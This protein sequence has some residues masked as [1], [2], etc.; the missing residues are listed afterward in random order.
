MSDLVVHEVLQ[1]FR[2]HEDHWS[3]LIYLMHDLEEHHDA[4]V[5]LGHVGGGQQR[6]ISIRSFEVFRESV[7][8]EITHMRTKHEQSLECLQSLYEHNAQCLL[9]ITALKEENQRLKRN[10]RDLAKVRGL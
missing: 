4:E 10:Q 8:E 3:R 7:L 5:D 2:S 6:H 9:S 1:A